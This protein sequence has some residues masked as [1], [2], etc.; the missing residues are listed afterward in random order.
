MELSPIEQQ[1]IANM[2]RLPQDKQQSLL[3]FSLFLID[4]AQN[5]AKKKAAVNDTFATFLATFLNEVANEPL[6]IDD[7]STLFRTHG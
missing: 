4:T 2:H 3:E 5:S 7:V 1:V 6:D